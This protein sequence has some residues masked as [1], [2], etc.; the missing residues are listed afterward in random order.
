MLLYKEIF[1][2]N[3]SIFSFQWTGMKRVFMFNYLISKFI[4]L[5]ELRKYSLIKKVILLKRLWNISFSSIPFI[6]KS[7]LSTYEN[8][9]TLYKW[10]FLAISTNIIPRTWALPSLSKKTWKLYP[11]TIYSW[12]WLTNGLLLDVGG[13]LT[14]MSYVKKVN[15]CCFFFK[16]LPTWT[17]L[18]EQYKNSLSSENEIP[19]LL[20]FDEDIGFTSIEHEVYRYLRGKDSM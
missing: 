5:I 7:T 18:H 16:C 3:N 1:I 6:K 9:S 11:L 10:E 4:Q 2:L 19:P 14:I 13:S 8:N 20:T 12:W 17:I 15:H